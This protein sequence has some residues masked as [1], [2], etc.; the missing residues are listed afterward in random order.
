[1]NSTNHKINQSIDRLGNSRQLY[2][3]MWEQYNSSVIQSD[4]REILVLFFL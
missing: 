3:L 4:D 1:M 2:K